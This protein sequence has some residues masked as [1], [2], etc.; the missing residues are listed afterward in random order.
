MIL[1]STLHY[2]TLRKTILVTHRCLHSARP[3]VHSTAMLREAFFNWGNIATNRDQPMHRATN[4]VCPL[5]VEDRPAFL[6][7][8]QRR[9]RLARGV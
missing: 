5:V 8:P 2:T 3:W 7:S 9:M 4:Q 1:C 6:D